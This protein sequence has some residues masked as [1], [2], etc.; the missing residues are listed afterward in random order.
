VN[1]EAAVIARSKLSFLQ[2]NGQYKGMRHL[3]LRDARDETT[4]DGTPR[5]NQG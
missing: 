2:V 5:L 4:L 3:A 1:L